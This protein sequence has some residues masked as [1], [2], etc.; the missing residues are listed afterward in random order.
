M[1]MRSLMTM[2]LI[3]S[4][5]IQSLVRAMLVSGFVEDGGDEVEDAA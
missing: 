5:V 1:T 4:I 3:I 2:K